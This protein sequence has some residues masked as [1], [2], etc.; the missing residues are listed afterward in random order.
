MRRI[1]VSRS[2]ERDLDDIW[3]YIARRSGSVEVANRL[4]DEI[5]ETFSL[6]ARVPG[7]GTVR[8]AILP[9]LRGFPVGN[10][11]VYYSE[12][13]RRVAITRVLH[14][15]RDQKSAYGKQTH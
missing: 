14:G 7:A 15:M 4:I 6:L 5:T 13:E 3:L 12:S 11:I 8:D 2:A 10:Y 9:G 1:R